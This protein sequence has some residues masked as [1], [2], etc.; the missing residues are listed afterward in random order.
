[1]CLSA[2]T[3]VLHLLCPGHIWRCFARVCQACMFFS[4]SSDDNLLGPSCAALELRLPCGPQS[5]RYDIARAVSGLT[6][7]LHPQSVVH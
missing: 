6:S 4:V 2:Q 7:V 3:H 1:M 5:K